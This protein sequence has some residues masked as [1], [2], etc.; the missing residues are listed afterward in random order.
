MGPVLYL[1]ALVVTYGRQTG[2]EFNLAWSPTKMWSP[3]VKVWSSQF[4]NV[5]CKKYQ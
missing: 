2:P 4:K 3:N 5:E 1:D